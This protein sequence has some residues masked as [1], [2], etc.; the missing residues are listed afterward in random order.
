MKTKIENSIKFIMRD[1]ICY[2]KSRMRE[3]GIQLG[4]YGVMIKA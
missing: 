1:V 2:P 4:I 3:E